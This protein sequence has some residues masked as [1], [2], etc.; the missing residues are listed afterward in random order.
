MV[1]IDSHMDDTVY[2][3]NYDAY[4]GGCYRLTLTVLS[5]YLFLALN[6]LH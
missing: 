4:K 6:I 3:Q 1:K 5:I 2:F